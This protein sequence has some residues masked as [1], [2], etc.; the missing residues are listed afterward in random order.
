MFTQNFRLRL[1]ALR[2]NGFNPSKILDIGAYSGEWSQGI[3]EIFPN[4]EIFM[5]EGNSDHKKSLKQT[6]FPYGIYMLSDKEKTAV[7]Y[8]TT[9]DITTGNSLYRENTEYFADD[10]CYSKK[11]ECK[12]LDSICNET[13]DLIKLDVQGS[14]KDIILG[15][16]NTIR[17]CKYLICELSVQEYNIGS[18]YIFEVQSLLENLGFRLYDIIDLNYDPYTGKLLQTDF[19]FVNTCE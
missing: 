7:Y 12:T 10:L 5:I 17:K 14:E 8:K 4:S 13:Y 11:V 16:V 2:D 3:K 9:S 1:K 6:G 18:P 15:G 19:M